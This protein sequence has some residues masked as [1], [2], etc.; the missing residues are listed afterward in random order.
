MSIMFDVHSFDEVNLEPSKFPVQR[1]S[2]SLLRQKWETGDHQ[3]VGC[4]PGGSHCRLFQ[5]QKSRLLEPGE[6]VSAPGPPGP[7]SQPCSAGA[8]LNSEPQE[9]SPQ[10]KGEN[11]R[12]HGRPEV[13][14]EDP[15]R[16]P[17]RIERFSIA[18]DKLRSVFEAPRSGNSPA[19]PAEYG[20]KEV[21]IERRLC[22]PTFRSHPGSQANDSVKDSDKKGMQTSS[23]KTS[24]ERGHRH[25]FTG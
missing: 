7:P 2:L 24:P 4:S 21:E 18:L 8:M 19:G 6:A 5:P 23:D 3:K 14:K 10:H 9:M 25:I 16:G 11:P 12:E 17:R 1:G 15:L 13:L 20:R 22:S